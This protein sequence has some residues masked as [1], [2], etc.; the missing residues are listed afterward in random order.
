MRL[1][2]SCLALFSLLAT[3][4]C[5][6]GQGDPAMVAIVDV[7][8]I[9]VAEG[10]AIPGQTIVVVGD[11]IERMGPVAE[12]ALPGDASI[13]DGRGL[14]LM[15]GLVDAHVHFLDASTFAL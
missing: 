3:P 8:V 15:P 7:T 12:I 4:C 13:L 10:V 2:A 11:R 6:A 14:Y 1:G 9:D 5:A